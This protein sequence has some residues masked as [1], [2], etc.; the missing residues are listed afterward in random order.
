MLGSTSVTSART[1]RR[2]LPLPRTIGTKSIWVPKSRYS[3]VVTPRDCGTGIGIWPPTRKLAGR[4]LTVV[5]VGSERSCAR[6]LRSRASRNPWKFSVPS[7]MP[8][9]SVLL[10]SGTA[11]ETSGR[12][13]NQAGSTLHHK[14]VAGNVRPV[15]AEAAEF[16]PRD[17]HDFDMEHDLLHAADRHAV[18]DVREVVLRD[19]ND[20]RHRLGFGNKARDVQA[21]V[22]RPQPQGGF[23]KLGLEHPVQ[24]LHIAVD[25][26]VDGGDLVVASS[27]R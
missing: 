8:K 6:L 19:L 18:D 22:E 1:S 25:D 12:G 27:R 5:K 20:L 13:R 3:M 7:V 11:A 15:K 14:S 17:F 24:L 21:A 9:R 23:G 2:T 16:G 10:A 26:D 4:P